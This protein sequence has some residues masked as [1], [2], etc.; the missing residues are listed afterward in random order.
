MTVRFSLEEAGPS[1][2]KGSR[3]R[4]D[5]VSGI[6]GTDMGR[7]PYLF[8][9]SPEAIAITLHHSIED[10]IGI[11]S[12][13]GRSSIAFQPHPSDTHV[14]AVQSRVVNPRP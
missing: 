14:L 11:E 8:R 9:C 4:R 2:S 13:T 7:F 12:G 6:N 10:Q 3:R 5:W 1:N